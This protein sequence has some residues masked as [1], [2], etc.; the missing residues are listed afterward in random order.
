M[1]DNSKNYIANDLTKVITM[2]VTC[3]NG[4]GRLKRKLFCLC[5]CSINVIIKPNIWN[6]FLDVINDYFW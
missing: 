2:T 4:Q 3:C 5:P 6:K 1:I